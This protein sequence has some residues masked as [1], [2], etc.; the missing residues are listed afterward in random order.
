MFDFQQVRFKNILDLP[1]LSIDESKVTSIVGASGSGK[2]TVLRLLN[3]M[4]S[5]TEGKIFY[6][7]KDLE[8]IDSVSHRRE[9]V[10]LPQ[11]PISFAGTV[12]EELNAGLT[13]QKQEPAADER[14]EELLQQLKLRK[15]LDEETGKLSGGELQRLALG[16]VILLDAPVYLLDEPSSA[17]DSA[18]ERLII[19][20]IT[21]FV[22]EKRKTLV[23]VTHSP[24]IA[25]RYS[26]QIIEIDSGRHTN[27]KGGKTNG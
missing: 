25:E 21:S 27:G 11:N 5:P 1:S 18:T 22:C 9:V 15:S 2:T 10:M 7:G 6:Q 8:E 12:R 14:L 4:I 3:K 26:D 17:L 24:D 19:E 20:L 13:F 23:M 16:R